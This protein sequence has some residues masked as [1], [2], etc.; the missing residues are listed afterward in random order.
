M[1]GVE[2]DVLKVW[3]TGVKPGGAVRVQQL[4]HSQDEPRAWVAMGG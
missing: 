1:L 2:D 3:V 4:W